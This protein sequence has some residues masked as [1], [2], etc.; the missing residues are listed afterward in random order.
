MDIGKAIEYERKVKFD[1]IIDID[2]VCRAL[3]RSEKLGKITGIFILVTFKEL[4]G[5]NA[6]LT[7]LYNQEDN[8]RLNGLDK[9]IA[10]R[11][12]RSKSVSLKKHNKKAG[13]S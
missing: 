5:F 8:A 1:K 11:R 10:R 6:I 7:H 9:K 3:A 13:H 2:T 12:E 4:P